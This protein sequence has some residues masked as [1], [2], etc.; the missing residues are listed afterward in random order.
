MWNEKGKRIYHGVGII[1]EDIRD[2]L[3]LSTSEWL[4][5]FTR[6]AMDYLLEKHSPETLKTL[7]QLKDS[8]FLKTILK[9]DTTIIQGC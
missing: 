4:K 9:V 5:H 3:T 6:E 2:N 7:E 8:E 1:P